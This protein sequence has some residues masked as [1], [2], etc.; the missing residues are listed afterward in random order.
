[1]VNAEGE[2]RLENHH[3]AIVIVKIGSGK[4]HQWMLNLGDISDD[5]Q[6]IYRVIKCFP[7]IVYQSQ[8]QK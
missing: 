6:D 2:L 5:K 4:N 3:F 7:Q 1:M 8:G